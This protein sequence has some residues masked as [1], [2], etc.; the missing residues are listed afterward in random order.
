MADF[1]SSLTAEKIEQKLVGG[2]VYDRENNLTEAQKAFVRDEIGA[3]AFGSGT[4]I[5]AHFDTLEELEMA[6]LNPSPEYAYSVGTVKPYDLYAYDFYHNA[7]RNYGPIRYTDITARFVSNATILA[8]DWVE[9]TSLFVDYTWRARITVEEI[10]KN[11][12][13]LVAF[14]PED[15]AGGNFCPVAFSFDGY[16]EIWAKTAPRSAMTVPIITFIV[17]NFDA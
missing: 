13:P 6:V 3:S 11:D 15:A 10:T 17:Q 1:I 16:V 14:Y 4:H 9:D 5:L 7:W 12:F 2:F 8:D